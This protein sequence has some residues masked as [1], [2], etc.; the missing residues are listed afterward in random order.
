MSIEEE[1]KVKIAAHLNRLTDDIMPVLRELIE[2]DYP[3]EVDALAFEI[4]VDGFSSEFPVRAF[5]MDADDS[6]YFIMVD[7]KAEYPSPVDP[8]LLK[9]DYVYPYDFEEEYTEKD[10]SL[11]PWHVATNELIEWFSKC[12]L[13]AGGKHFK[14]NAN[15]APHDGNHEFDLKESKWVTR[16]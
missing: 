14:L 1:F 2:Y 10:D 11:D 3:K 16:W 5:F 13:A 12:W 9:I 7:G 4:F 6:E 8:R 15:I